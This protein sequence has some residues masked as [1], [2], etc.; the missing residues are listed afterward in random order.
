MA[1]PVKMYAVGTPQKQ[2]TNLLRME[3]FHRNQ[4]LEAKTMEMGN[5][6]YNNANVINKTKQDIAE[7][8]GFTMDTTYFRTSPIFR[9]EQGALYYFK[10]FNDIGNVKTFLT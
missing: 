8:H 6:N 9:D 3:V 7:R 2:P 5:E 4:F 10:W 1:H